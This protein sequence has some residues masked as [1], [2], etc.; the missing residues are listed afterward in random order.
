MGNAE[1]I[2]SQYPLTGGRLP[3][4]VKIVELDG[5]GPPVEGQSCSALVDREGEKHL[6]IV[7]GPLQDR[8]RTDEF[9]DF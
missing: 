8:E 2:A 7:V 4:G 6:V 9:P 1:N 3:E 5:N